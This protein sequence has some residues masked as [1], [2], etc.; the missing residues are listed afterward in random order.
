M[1]V[2]QIKTLAFLKELS[3]QAITEARGG[4]SI[5]A[6]RLA[7]NPALKHYFE[8]RDLI[9]AKVWARDYPHLLEEAD[10][11]RVA[12]EE[13][14]QREIERKETAAKVNSL[15]SKLD[16]LS[17]QLAAFM[18]S[19]KPAEPAKG[20]GRKAKVEADPEP[21]TGEETEKPEGEAT[22]GE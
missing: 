7:G 20:K 1:A 14:E 2:D 6:N 13:A 21:E 12:A 4:N 15:E 9:Q 11:I 10:R 17:Q 16:V 18:E 8:N 3:E 19:Q 22:E 5:L